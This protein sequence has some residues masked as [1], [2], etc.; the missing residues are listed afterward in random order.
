MQLFVSE[1]TFEPKTGVDKD[2]ASIFTFGAGIKI[3]TTT[4]ADVTAAYFSFG[5]GSVVTDVHNLGGS[6]EG[7]FSVW[8]GFGLEIPIS[9]SI[10]SFVDSKLICAPSEYCAVVPIQV[11]L[12]IPI[13]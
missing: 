13:R 4:Q 3:P 7:L 11:G 9:D 2:A 12:K 10:T 6:A 5:L 1:N 8:G